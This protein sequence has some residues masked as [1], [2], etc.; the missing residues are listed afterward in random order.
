MIAGHFALVAAA[1]FTGAALFIDIVGQRT[2]L[3]LDDRALFAQWKTAHKRG[4]A[5]QATL[6]VVGGVLGMVAWWQS[7]GLLW[8]L[9]AMVLLADRPFWLLGIMPTNQRLQAI[10]PESAGAQSRALIYRWDRL[11]A[12]R[13]ALGSLA[14][15]LFFAASTR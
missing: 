13:S 11:H 3:M 4:F 9:G 8:G 5:M 14:F 1:A 10:T 15:L 7:G 12:L 2:R 6:A